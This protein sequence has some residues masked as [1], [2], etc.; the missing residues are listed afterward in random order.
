ESGRAWR[1]ESE[2]P[3]GIGEHWRRG[4]SRPGEESGLEARGQRCQ[5]TE[6]ASLLGGEIDDID[7]LDERYEDRCAVRPKCSDVLRKLGDDMSKASRWDSH[8]ESCS[9]VDRAKR[10]LRR[11]NRVVNGMSS[12]PHHAFSI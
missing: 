4:L 3:V 9:D 2:P 1:T 8:L 12:M 10:C 6:G 5:I 7:A 11:S